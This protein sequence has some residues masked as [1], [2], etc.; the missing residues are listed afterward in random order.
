MNTA[1]LKTQFYP[2]ITLGFQAWTS[3]AHVISVHISSIWLLPERE[4]CRND[5]EVSTPSPVCHWHYIIFISIVYFTSTR[6]CHW[7]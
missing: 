5:S 3:W 6:K 7:I 4:S 2:D 1:D